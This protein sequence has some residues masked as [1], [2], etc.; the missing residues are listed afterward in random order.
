MDVV[1]GR[2]GEGGGWDCYLAYLADLA[3]LLRGDIHVYINSIVLQSCIQSAAD[4]QSKIFSNVQ[5][6]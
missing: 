4:L 3:R 2:G 5:G 6:G 1:G